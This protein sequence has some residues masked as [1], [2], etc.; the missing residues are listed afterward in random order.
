MIWTKSYLPHQPQQIQQIHF[1]ILDRYEK[2]VALKY[3]LSEVIS[4]FRYIFS[5]THP[6]TPFI[7]TH[8]LVLSPHIL[9]I[10]LNHRELHLSL[11]QLPP[12]FVLF[13]TIE[14]DNSSFIFP[15]NILLYSKAYRIIDCKYK[16]LSFYIPE[17][18]RY[19]FYLPFIQKSTTEQIAVRDERKKKEILFYTHQG[20]RSSIFS[21]LII[22]QLKERSQKEYEYEYIFYDPMNE[23]LFEEADIVIRLYDEPNPYYDNILFSKCMKYQKVCISEKCDDVYH[24]NYYFDKVL[25]EKLDLIT[26]TSFV[27]KIHLYLSD[28]TKIQQLRSSMKENTERN[29]LQAKLIFEKI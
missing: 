3:Q 7:T 15:E 10:F 25:F 9:Y 11:P 2:E 6:D 20:K 12:L 23:E 27:D 1:L 21:H 26:L 22:Q 8:Q 16:N 5:H 18:K 17:V 19:T 28:N 14:H 29:I 4:F 24:E 13:N